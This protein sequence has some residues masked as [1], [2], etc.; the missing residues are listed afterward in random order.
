MRG[1]ARLAAMPGAKRLIAASALAA[2]LLLSACGD[3][4][5][6]PSLPLEDAE[7]LIATLGEIQS[8]VEVG[9]CVVAREKVGE[10]RTE[11]EQL[12]S[13]VDEDLRRGMENGAD[14]LEILVSDPDRCERPEEP[15]T[16]TE[17]T[18]PEEEPEPTTTEQ[19]TEPETTTEQTQPTTQTQP[20]GGGGGTGGLGPSG[21]GQ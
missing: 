17:E 1:M 10:L 6:E 15:E 21:G 12:P 20:G 5:P 19:E 7:T 16:T 4:E 11:I 14:Q 8:N 9:S 2:A 18:E 3:D 13:E